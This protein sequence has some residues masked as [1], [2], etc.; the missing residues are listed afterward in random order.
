MKCCRL[1]ASSVY[2]IQ[3]CTNL[4]CHLIQSHLGRVYVCLAVTCHLHFWQNDRDL[5]RVITESRHWRRKFSRRSCRDANT[6]AF[7]H[8]LDALTTE[9]SPLP[10]YRRCTMELSDKISHHTQGQS[11]YTFSF[12]KPYQSF[13]QTYIYYYYIICRTCAT[14]SETIR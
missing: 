4:R 5:L 13:H 8:E 2:T 9:L 7:D 1:S 10:K 11:T 14:H 3:P 12:I 6:G